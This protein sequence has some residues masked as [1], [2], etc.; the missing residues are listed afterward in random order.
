MRLE[1][2][3][4]VS[5]LV[6]AL[7]LGAVLLATAGCNTVKGFGRDLEVLGERLQGRDPGRSEPVSAPV[8]PAPA[9]APTPAAGG[10]EPTVEVYPYPSAP[11][12]D[13]TAP[14][15]KKEVTPF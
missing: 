2:K 12:A 14:P 8:T 4:C 7:A 9:P 15:R 13:A 5:R 6:L 1:G 10:S 11:P 3:R